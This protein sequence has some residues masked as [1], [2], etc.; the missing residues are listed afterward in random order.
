MPW[1]RS[2]RRSRIITI[3]L[4]AGGIA[5]CLRVDGDHTGVDRGCLD[6]LFLFS[7]SARRTA[8]Y[9]YL[10]RDGLPREGCRADSGCGRAVSGTGSRRG[11]GQGPQLHGGPHRLHRLLYVGTGDQRGRGQSWASASEGG[12]PRH[13]SFARGSAQRRTGRF[14]GCVTPSPG[15]T[16]ARFASG[17]VPAVSLRAAVRFTTPWHECWSRLTPRRN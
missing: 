15:V 11:Y 8:H 6:V 10:S 4:P 12:A 16:T 1:Y 13:R 17:S 7:P 9:Q 14:P 2:C 3:I 5:A